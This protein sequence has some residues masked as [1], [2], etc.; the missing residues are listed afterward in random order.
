MTRL[1]ALVLA[2]V[3]AAPAPAQFIPAPGQGARGS[4]FSPITPY[5]F[6]P[7]VGVRVNSV[8]GSFVAGQQ[9]PFYSP[10]N[11]VT[12]IPFSYWYVRPQYA[13]GMANS[14]YGS[15]GAPVTSGYM[16]GGTVRNNV[17]ESSQKDFER[18]QRDA[19][20]A[21]QMATPDTAKNLIYDQWAYERLGQIGGLTGLK[22][23]QPEELSKALAAE[24]GELNSGEALNHILVAI[25]A[26]EA[27]GPK[28]LS[29]FLPPAVLSDV[30]FSGPPAADVLNLVR[31]AGALPFPAAFDDPKL[32]AVRETLEKDFEA[33]AAP[34]AAGKPGNPTA[35]ARVGAALAKAQEQATPVIRDL[36]FAEAAAARRFLNR[37]EKALEVMKAPSA[38]ALVVPAWA[39]DGAGVADL[40]RHMTKHKLLFGP[41]PPGD[42]TAYAAVHKALSAY[43]FSLTQ[44]KK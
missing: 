7:Y 29:A 33:A 41:A 43:L 17:V 28:G 6:Q 18:L 12:N 14:G 37:F 42:D 9:I 2:A 19:T 30:R 40:V 4:P 20:A 35:L 27:K 44:V 5:R 10:L 24:D 26:A 13:Y 23:D 16:S 3:A 34:L 39:T 1:S 38:A 22:G 15:G 31:Q 36:P 25:V 32:K 21:R 11:N 8:Y